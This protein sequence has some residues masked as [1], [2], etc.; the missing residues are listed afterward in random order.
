[1][2]TIVALNYFF[3]IEKAETSHAI[4]LLAQL[5]YLAF[6]ERQRVYALFIKDIPAVSAAPL[7]PLVKNLV[8]LSVLV[9][10]LFLLWR[11][12]TLHPKP[13]LSGKYQ[14]RNLLFDHHDR[15]TQHCTDSLLTRVYFDLGNECIFEFNSPDRRWYGTY[16]LSDDNRK[17]TVA[18]H[19]PADAHDTLA[20]TIRENGMDSSLSI[21]GRIGKDS[22]RVSLVM[23]K[24][25]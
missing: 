22:I 18:W 11:Y 3:D 20:G 10:P 15:Q 1:M 23:G 12:S 24:R 16:Q 8:R 21:N 19:Y 14:I 4:E 13:W 6:A 7:K 5:L 9:I 25:R 17:I 2:V